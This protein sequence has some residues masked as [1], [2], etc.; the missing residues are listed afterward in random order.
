MTPGDTY[1]VSR[2]SDTVAFYH[3]GDVHYVWKVEIPDTT[4]V[5]GVVD[6]GRL[7]QISVVQPGK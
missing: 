4:H 6:M 5:W 7:D 3:N 2:Q 1:G